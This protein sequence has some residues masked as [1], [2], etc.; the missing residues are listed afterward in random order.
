MQALF[1]WFVSAND[2]A[3][4]T[5]LGCTECRLHCACMTILSQTPHVIQEIDLNPVIVGA[6]GEGVAVVDALMVQEARQR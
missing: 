3:L 6:E 1:Y 2:S 4:G 5:N